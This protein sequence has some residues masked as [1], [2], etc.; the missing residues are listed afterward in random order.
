MRTTSKELSQKAVAIV[1]DASKG[2][3]ELMTEKNVALI[4]F[5]TN[6]N[7]SD[8]DVDRSYI[9]V[10]DKYGIVTEQEIVAVY[11]DG[12]SLYILPDSAVLPTEVMNRLEEEI[13][14]Q[15]S[16]DVTVNFEDLKP[17]LWDIPD[18]FFNP[19]DTMIDL[20]A[21]VEQAL[22]VYDDLKTE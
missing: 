13:F 10:G 6:G 9:F 12:K 17:D 21:S 15:S 7:D 5:V 14:F 1:N 2:I 8:F 19:T 18:N 16:G 11:T 22:E 3:I 20:L 4:S